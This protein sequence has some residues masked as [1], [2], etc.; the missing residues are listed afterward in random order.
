MKSVLLIG[1][2][3]EGG[4]YSGHE[5]PE[6]HHGGCRLLLT[7]LLETEFHKD[8]RPSAGQWVSEAVCPPW[9]RHVP[10]CSTIIYRQTYRQ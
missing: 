5:R 2:T 7:P 10:H 4:A 9:V 1:S 8:R 6:S 3:V